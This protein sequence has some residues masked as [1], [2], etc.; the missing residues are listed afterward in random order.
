VNAQRYEQ[1]IEA[2]PPDVR[3]S[4]LAEVP[5]QKPHEVVAGVLARGEHVLLC[6]RR[7]GRWYPNAWD[8]PGGHIDPG[9]TASAALRRE[10]REELG[11][12]LSELTP[13]PAARLRTDGFDL[14]VWLVTAWSGEPEN[15]SPDEH[16]SIAWFPTTALRQLTL[17]DNRYITLIDQVLSDAKPD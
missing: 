2:G 12:D 17:A 7:A 4:A 16:D 11:I 8:L 1:D 6:H 5:A 14:R 15:T 13:E 3:P 10:L 9:E